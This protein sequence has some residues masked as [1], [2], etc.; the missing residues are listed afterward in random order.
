[1]H[2]IDNFG[3]DNVNNPNYYDLKMGSLEYDVNH[4]LL[5]E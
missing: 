5:Q 1:M 4:R 2:A 3:T